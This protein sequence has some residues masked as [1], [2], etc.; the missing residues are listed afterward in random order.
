MAYGRRRRNPFGSTRS[1]K[2]RS[3]IR[4]KPRVAKMGGKCDGC[5]TR[6]AAGENITYVITKKRK[7]HT[8]SCVPPNVGQMLQATQ[9]AA[10]VLPRTSMEAK[11]A[12]LQS[13]ENAL[14]VLAKEKNYPPELDKAFD[15]YKKLKALG[16]HTTSKNTPEGE[17]G[18]K[19]A[20]IAL[21]RAIF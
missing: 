4:V 13:L 2:I 20:T 9:Q 11:L 14:A 18:L 21:V 16:M 17:A 12:A 1:K 6:F 10:P 3:P 19:E 7:Y 15:R 5:K 8:G